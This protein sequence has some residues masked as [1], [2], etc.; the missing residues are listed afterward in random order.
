MWG[1]DKICTD[2]LCPELWRHC[3]YVLSF[4]SEE[5]LSPIPITKLIYITMEFGWS[6]ERRV[7]TKKWGVFYWEFTWRKLMP[8]LI[9]NSIFLNLFHGIDRIDSASAGY[10]STWIPSY[11]RNNWSPKHFFKMRL[12]LWEN[13]CT[14]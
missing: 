8:S 14:K 11:H 12:Y 7:N 10:N 13:G 9:L 4:I 2:D 6:N 5:L 1:N 3:M